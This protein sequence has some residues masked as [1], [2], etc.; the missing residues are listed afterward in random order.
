MG[1][2]LT[3]TEVYTHIHCKESRHEVMSLA[4]S[5]EKAA[6]VSSSFRSGRGNSLRRGHG[7]KSTNLSDDRDRL[8]CEHCGRHRHTKD[9]CWDLHERPLDLAPRTTTRGGFGN[10]RGGVALVDKDLVLTLFHLHLLSY[11]LNLH[12]LP[13]ILE[14]YLVMRLWHFDV[15]FLSL[16]NLPWP[17][18][19]PLL[20]QV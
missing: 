15:L 6:L 18:P 13:Q 20:T 3:L 12:F 7:S 9:Q 4:P 17:Q 16:I 5:I 11:L 8:K 10:G 19:P 2:L 1:H 14:F